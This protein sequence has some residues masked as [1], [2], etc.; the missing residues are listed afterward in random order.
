MALSRQARRR[1]AHGSN[2]TL[3]SAL[4]VGLAVVVYLIVDLHRV[5]VDLSADQGSVLRADTR[6]KLKL[7]DEGGE[8]TSLTASR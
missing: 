4:V 6:K 8:P 7:L 2:A 5:R 3:V 1:L